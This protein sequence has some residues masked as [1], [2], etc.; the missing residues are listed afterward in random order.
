MLSKE[1]CLDRIKE[2]AAARQMYGRLIFTSSS[3]CA[4][5]NRRYEELVE[6]FLVLP[7]NDRAWLESR[8]NEFGR[9]IIASCGKK[10]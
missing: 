5:Y 8:S 1:E 2:L 9:V 6:S 7:Q 4:S 3:L 10:L